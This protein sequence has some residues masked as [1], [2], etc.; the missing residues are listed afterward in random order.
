VD[1]VSEAMKASPVATAP[2]PHQGLRGKRAVFLD[3]AA[4]QGVAVELTGR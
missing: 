4:T 3:S 1:D 2:E